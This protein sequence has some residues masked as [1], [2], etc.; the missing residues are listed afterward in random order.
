MTDVAYL[1]QYDATD[2]RSWSG[3]GRA[4]AMCLREAGFQLHL[5][6]PLKN[7][8]HPI[9][10]GRYL[11]H[12][13]LLRHGD[14]PQRDPSFLRYFSRQAEQKLAAI[15][16]D[17]IFAPGGL[18]LSYLRTSLPVVLW[19]DCTFANLL[20]Y[21]PAFSNL[22]A[23][24]IRNGH[25]AELRTLSRCDLL[26]FSSQWAADSAISDY[27]INPDKIRIV[28]L[29]S[30]MP[31]VQTSDV[32]EMIARR[33]ATIGDKISLCLVGVDWYRKGA[34]VASAVTSILANNGISAELTV[35]GCE[36]P[37]SSPFWVKTTGFL[38][39]STPEGL[40]KL[41]RLFEDS[42]FIMLPSRADC[43]PIVLS[44]AASHG[45]PSLA[46]RTGGIASIV[47]NGVTG[48][49]F[50]PD[51]SPHV[52]ADCI[53]ALIRDP[54]RY[55]ALCRSARN[56]FEQRLNWIEAGKVVKRLIEEL[57][58]VPAKAA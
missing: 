42:H 49:M 27:G 18:P 50:M 45:L 16:A 8:L 2:V 7:Q 30:N 40:S 26:L 34:D 55:A 54:A 19:T 56:D 47:S 17:V 13:Y 39:K 41:A 46:S 25:D 37:G 36:P 24:S 52:W 3:T 28:P 11:A 29:G 35:A 58:P 33:A 4:M 14:H 32:E 51:E 15:N 1:S 6:G 48:H 23:R 44:E 10:V 43:T 31:A 22:S 21:Y 57:L 5:V 20:N 38:D 53:K 9:N 12:K